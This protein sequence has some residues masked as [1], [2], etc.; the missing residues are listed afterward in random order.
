MTRDLPRSGAAE[1]ISAID[2][3]FGGNCNTAQLHVPRGYEALCFGGAQIGKRPL[4]VGAEA[5]EL[6]HL[7]MRLREGHAAAHEF[8]GQM[9]VL[10]KNDISDMILTCNEYQYIVS[11]PYDEWQYV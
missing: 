8:V 10:D 11:P 7:F 3:A 5:H 1:N 6:S 2:R 4:L 9:Y